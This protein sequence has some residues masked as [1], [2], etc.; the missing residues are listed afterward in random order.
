MELMYQKRCVGTTRFLFKQRNKGRYICRY[1][2]DS[3]YKSGE[4]TEMYVHFVAS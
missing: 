3:Q 1:M 4:N 2:S